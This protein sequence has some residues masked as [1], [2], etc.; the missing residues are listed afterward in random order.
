[1]CTCLPNHI[2]GQNT[3]M[4]AMNRVS[5]RVSRC[6]GGPRTEGN[7]VFFRPQNSHLRNLCYH[8][9]ST[10]KI[11]YS[12]IKICQN[13]N[14][15][16]SKVPKLKFACKKLWVKH[17]FF[18]RWTSIIIAVTRACKWFLSKVVRQITFRI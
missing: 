3:I 12:P 14:W 13:I 18:A 17:P 1:M 5:E 9:H 6:S 11:V 15:L 7:H 2:S 4:D 8:A 10:L 16:A